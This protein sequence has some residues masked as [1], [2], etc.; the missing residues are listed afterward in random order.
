MRGILFDLDGVLYNSE[1]PIEGAAEAVQWVQDRGIPHLFVTNTTSRDRAALVQKMGRFG[2]RTKR[3][4]ILTPC[5]A[6]A[7]WLKDRKDGLAALFVD[8]RA[9]GEFEGVPCLPEEAESGAR[10]VVI[11]DLGDLWNFRRLNQAFRILNSSPETVLIALGMTRF[12]QAQD[13]LR[14][15]VAP[16]IVAL[17][18]AAGKKSVVFGKPADTFFRAAVEKL[19][20]A[21]HEI[22]MIGDSIETDIAGAQQTGIRGVLVRTGKFRQEDLQ[23]E[24]RPD[25]VLNSIREVPAWWQKA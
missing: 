4:S 19:H 8:R 10:Y 15:D 2:I 20:M 3:D 6:A 22:A 16:F 12:Y 11:G 18:H 5:I 14:L 25:V 7:E 21:P 23:G 1:E 9:L 13:G 24:V 17:E